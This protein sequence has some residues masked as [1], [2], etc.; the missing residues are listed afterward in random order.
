MAAMRPESTPPARI[1]FDLTTLHLF[2]ATAELGE[3]CPA[4]AALWRSNCPTVRI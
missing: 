3:R 1:H 4:C 2:I